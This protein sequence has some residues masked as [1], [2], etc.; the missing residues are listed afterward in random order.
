VGHADRDHDQPGLGPEQAQQQ[1]R[2]HQLRKGQDYIDAA[3]DDP[4]R[5]SA[6]VGGRDARRGAEHD[7]DRRRGHGHEQQQ[8]PADQHPGQNVPA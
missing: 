7:A 4:V 5:R 6:Q 8:A 2:E 3:H 1:Q